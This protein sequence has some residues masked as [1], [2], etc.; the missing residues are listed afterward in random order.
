MPIDK[1]GREYIIVGRN[2]DKIPDIFKYQLNGKS[3]QE[4]YNDIKRK[5]QAERE[6]KREFEKQLNE[7]LEKQIEEKLSSLLESKLEELLKGF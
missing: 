3:I 5:R 7:E 4:N 1:D 2:N 6:Q